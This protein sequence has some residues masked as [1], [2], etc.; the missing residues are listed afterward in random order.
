M[1][2]APTT[3][4]QGWLLGED[5]ERRLDLS[6]FYT[7]AH[8][9]ERMW[10]WCSSAMMPHR[11]V[12][13]PS[14]GRGSLIRPM[15]VQNQPRSITAYDV[16]PRN[17][18]DLKRLMEAAP[19]HVSATVH[20]R[21]FLA[22][23]NPGPFDLIPMNPPYEDDQDIAHLDHAMDHSRMTVAL[24]RSVIV[25]G[26]L[27]WRKFWRHVDIRRCANLISRPEFATGINPQTCKP[28]PG[29]KAD[30]VVLDLSRR[31]TARKQGYVS[32]MN[33]EWWP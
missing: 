11:D 3:P 29:P 18:R 32:T 12:C 21:D 10:G 17:V 4:H 13:E 24:V 22:D 14:A 33:V 2:D 15:L 23:P 19:S 20:A 8:I 27:R 16:D 28:F 5:E 7:P 6:Q 26:D 9:A 30:F 25:H 31:N 1:T